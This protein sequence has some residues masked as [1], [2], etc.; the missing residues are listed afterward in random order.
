MWFYKGCRCKR[1]F[2]FLLNVP[3][4]CQ[5]SHLWFTRR[6]KFNSQH[7]QRPLSE[8]TLGC[9]E[10]CQG[11]RNTR[12]QETQWAT[13]GADAWGG[14]RDLPSL[15]QEVSLKGSRDSSMLFSDVTRQMPRRR[16]NWFS[17]LRLRKQG[18]S[19]SEGQDQEMQK[20][21]GLLL[22]NIRNDGKW[23]WAAGCFGQ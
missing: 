22:T 14:G 20:E 4:Y 3:G 5:V 18:A 9:P 13:V 21:S 11:E 6:T 15:L 16:V 10:P 19:K 1:V 7:R 2:F 17:S 8:G 12:K 23:G